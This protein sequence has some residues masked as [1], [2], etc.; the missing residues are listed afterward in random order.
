MNY[1][2]NRVITGHWA[3]PRPHGKY[4]EVF[5]P[6]FFE[7]L[8]TLV[9]LDGKRVLHLFC[10]SSQLGDVRIDI[11]AKVKPDHVLD[12]SKDKI[13][14]PDNSFDIVIADPPYHDLNPYCFVR[15]AARILKP[16]GYLIIL[17]FLSYITP[18]GMQRTHFIT[19]SCG[20]N[21][22]VRALNIFRK[23]DVQR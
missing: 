13:P 1:E 20:P 7:R 16:R 18:R 6:T 15:E 8:K 3:L 23:E 2:I 22:R 10:G 11:N 19:I 4:K 5:P 17:H 21:T 12:L 14:Y 9:G